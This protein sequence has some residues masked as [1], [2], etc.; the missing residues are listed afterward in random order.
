VGP[1][2]AVWFEPNV[3]AT[4]WAAGC[5]WW[6]QPVDVAHVSVVQAI[7]SLQSCGV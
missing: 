1:H 6:A 5:G 7:P 2:V 3:T 4:A